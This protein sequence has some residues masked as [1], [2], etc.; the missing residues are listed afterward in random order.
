[1][2]C[3]RLLR[4][5][6]SATKDYDPPAEIE[7]A[8]GLFAIRALWLLQ[9][10]LMHWEWVLTISKGKK[11][12]DIRNHVFA[13]IGLLKHSKI[14]P[15]YSKTAKDVWIAVLEEVA[16]LNY[17]EDE[18]FQAAE[19]W[20]ETLDVMQDDEVVEDIWRRYANEFLEF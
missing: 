18:F 15:D 3:P 10:L 13:F 4:Q 16:L 7:E 9:A 8:L 5:G 12:E 14:S 20:R 6:G 11:C 17:D 19:L 1:M 2:V